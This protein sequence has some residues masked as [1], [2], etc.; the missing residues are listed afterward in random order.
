MLSSV[1]YPDGSAEASCERRIR[2][3]R[4]TVS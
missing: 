2:P 1:N 4:A 3:A